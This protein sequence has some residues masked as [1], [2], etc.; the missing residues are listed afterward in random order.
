MIPIREVNRDPLFR[1]IQIKKLSQAKLEKAFL[2]G[3]I[4]FKKLSVLF[5]VQLSV[6][7]GGHICHFGEEAGKIEFIAEAKLL[8]DEIERTV[9]VD[10]LLLY[11]LDA[12]LSDILRDSLT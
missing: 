2:F 8:T 3:E 9:V 1:I 4:D 11:S 7:R 5:A 10:D 6:L 12:L